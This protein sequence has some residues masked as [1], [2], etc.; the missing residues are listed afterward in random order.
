MQTSDDTPT[1]WDSLAILD[2][3]LDARY[4]LLPGVV[5]RAGREDAGGASVDIPCRDQ[6]VSRVHCELS[7]TRDGRLRIKDLSSYGTFVNGARIRGEGYAEAGDRVVLGHNY[8]LEVEGP[9]EQVKG[10]EDPFSGKTIAGKYQLEDLIGSGGFARVYRGRHVLDQRELAVKLILPPQSRE[11]R[12]RFLRE[13][14]IGHRLIHK[15]VVAV[16]DYG[17]EE[18]GLV[19][20]VMDLLE[21]QTL[22]RWVRQRRQVTAEEVRSI[23]V[24]VLE[25]LSEAHAR[26]IVHRDLKPNNL[27]IGDAEDGNPYVWVL[28]FGIAKDVA[29]GSLTAPGSTVGTFR[30]MSPEQACGRTVDPRSDLYAL[31]TVLYELLCN[32]HPVAQPNL[33][34]SQLMR[35]ISTVEP[36]HLDALIPGL[37]GTLTQAVMRNLS[38][39]VSERHGD[40]ESFRLALLASRPDQTERLVPSKLRARLARDLVGSTPFDDDDSPDTESGPATGQ[41]PALELG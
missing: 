27:M 40:A 5:L 17:E 34:R 41:G 37:D 35:R 21:G 28:D 36:A 13:V 29:G 3:K 26:G 4:P 16:R 10:K 15:H 14:D 11:V 7:A 32:R 22:D 19:Y 6:H 20:L 33:P 24:Q 9:P 1:R 30:Y 25:A 23:G 39:D 2:P 12:Q 31:A 18:D 38:K 8:A